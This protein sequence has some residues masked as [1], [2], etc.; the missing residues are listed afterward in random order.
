MVPHGLIPSDI[1]VS[2]DSLHTWESSAKTQASKVLFD[3]DLYWQP[4]KAADKGLIA[5][6]SGRFGAVLQSIHLTIMRPTQRTYVHVG[7]ERSQRFSYN[8]PDIV[9]M[10]I[11]QPSWSSIESEILF[12][13]L[14]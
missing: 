4:L 6:V 5:R 10:S 8:S 11:E 7:R 3:A 9:L 13:V 14:A 1:S 12:L 2:G